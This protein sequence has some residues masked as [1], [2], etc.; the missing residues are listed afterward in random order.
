MAEKCPLCSGPAKCVTWTS[1]GMLNRYESTAI[2]SVN[3]W[4]SADDGDHTPEPRG[5]E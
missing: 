4:E 3:S 2:V 5:G 1:A